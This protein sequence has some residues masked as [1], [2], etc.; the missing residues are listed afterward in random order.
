MN[1]P[2]TAKKD[3]APGAESSPVRSVL[4]LG[5]SY[6]YFNDMPSMFGATAHEAGYTV[7]V[8][9][10]T[11]GGC[12]LRQFED[13]TDPLYEKLHGILETNR[14]DTA[15]LQEQSVLPASNPDAFLASARA[16][17]DKLRAHGARIYLYQTWGR[18]EPSETLT[19]HGW[20]NQSMTEK[21]AK[22]YTAAAK[23][24]SCGRSPVGAA[25]SKVGEHFPQIELYNPDHSHPSVAGSYLAALC[26]FAALFGVS[27]EGLAYAAGLP[28]ETACILQSAAAAAVLAADKNE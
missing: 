2:N 6:T 24:L 5:N 10:I 22:A 19:K 12:F 17:C 18:K 15:V 8:E 9:S 26:H 4:F 13:S 1:H 11:R 23:A 27:P 25:F 28:K 21:L 7:K 20:T 3:A 14:F 16:L